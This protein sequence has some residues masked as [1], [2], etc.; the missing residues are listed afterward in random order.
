MCNNPNLLTCVT[1]LP[2][3]LMVK[4]FLLYHEPNIVKALRI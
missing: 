1:K 3:P 4:R 2:L